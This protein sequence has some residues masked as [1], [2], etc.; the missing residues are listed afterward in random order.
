M[1]GRT[2]EINCALG[3]NAERWINSR[4]IH[5]NIQLNGPLTFDLIRPAQIRTG[6]TRTS[7]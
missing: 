2:Q 6:R 5:T 4:Y 1:H 3:P 7:F